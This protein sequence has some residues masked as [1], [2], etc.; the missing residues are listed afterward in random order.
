MRTLRWKSLFRS[1]KHAR[2]QP[3][4]GTLASRNRLK[5]SGLAGSEF[6]GLNSVRDLGST[7]ADRS[8]SAAGRLAGRV[9]IARCKTVRDNHRPRGTC[10]EQVRENSAARS[11]SRQVHRALVAAADRLPL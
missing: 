2:V 7:E 9:P 4:M 11:I 8:S 3:P 5:K 1:T 6:R 10:H